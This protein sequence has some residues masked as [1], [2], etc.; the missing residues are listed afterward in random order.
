MVIRGSALVDDDVSTD[1]RDA[2]ECARQ[3]RAVNFFPERGQ[4]G[5]EAKAICAVCPVQQP[6]LEFALHTDVSCGVWGGTTESERR[7]LRRQQPT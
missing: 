2:A 4:S 1:W 7:L 5:M 3:T 6:C